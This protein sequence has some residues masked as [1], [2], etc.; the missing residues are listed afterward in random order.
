MIFRQC[1]L[2]KCKKK[3]TAWIPEQFAHVNKVL[4]IKNEDGWKVVEVSSQRFS[5]EY[6]LERA[7]DYKHQAQASDKFT[8][9]R[10]LDIHGS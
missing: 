2:Q 3:Q 1:V 5:E 9:N 6:V 7:D 4:K 10:G 8:P